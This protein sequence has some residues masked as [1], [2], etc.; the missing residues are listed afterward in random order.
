MKKRTGFGTT[1]WIYV[2]VSGCTERWTII[3]EFVKIT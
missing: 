3:K 2:L 1:W